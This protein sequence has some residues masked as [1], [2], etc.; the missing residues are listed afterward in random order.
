M[1]LLTVSTLEAT[2]RSLVDEDLL[3]V[4]ASGALWTV[5][6]AVTTT[7]NSA[8]DLTLS[9]A[10][11][12]G[13]QFDDA[14]DLSAGINRVDLTV[15]ASGQIAALDGAGVDIA[16]DFRALVTNAGMISGND[17][18]LVM[19][20]TD[21]AADLTVNNSGALIS[22]EVEALRMGVGTGIGTL[23]NTGTIS[24]G[25]DRDAVRFSGAATAL[26]EM[27]NDGRI[28]TTDTAD[29]INV[30]GGRLRLV[31][32]GTIVGNVNAPFAF[33]VVTN[34]GL[35][36][37]DITFGEEGGRYTGNGGRLAGILF[38]GNGDTTIT[39][40]RDVTLVELAGGGDDRYTTSQTHTD[41]A[42]H[43][44]F[45]ILTAG[46]VS[47]TGNF[48]ANEITGNGAANVLAGGGGFDSMSGRG[49]DDTL[50]GNS[51]DDRFFGGDGEDVL[52]GNQ[53]NDSMSGD[54]GADRLFG[55]AGNDRLFGGDDQDSLFGGS[56]NDTLS[57]GLDD[58]IS[59][60]GAG[61][62]FFEGTGADDTMSGGTGAD[63]LRGGEGRDVMTGGA[64]ADLFVFVGTGDSRVSAP[65]SI[66]DFQRGTDRID[67]SA[68]DANGNLAGSPAFTFIGAR[69]FS[70]P[71]EVQ[72]RPWVGDSL[73]VDVNTVGTGGSE[74]VFIVDAD[75]P[76][77][78]ATDFIL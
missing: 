24:G 57:H 63:T 50:S 14:I 23:I 27:V 9:V 56:G 45:L 68:I 35:I 78:R 39:T 17:E 76:E 69:A 54:E 55:G 7:T 8:A 61:S 71:G 43:V 72:F 46:A 47:G 20:A 19:T 22:T 65:D 18:A 31:N 10:G 58:D 16:V 32:T 5:D 42:D 60:G 51:G 29:A 3:V 66:T 38:G 70:K 53:Q 11:A 26:L 44:E 49:G 33:S 40:D 2:Q 64:D 59:F 34:S 36:D 15:A 28:V 30:D 25:R 41:L 52:H 13:S 48:T 21:A 77:L 74:M 75:A 12:I 73:R 37:G 1:A 6:A 4:T 62:D 67:L